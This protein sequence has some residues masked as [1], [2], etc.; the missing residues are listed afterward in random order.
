MDGITL[1][2]DLDGT[3]IDTAPDLIHAANHAMTLAGLPAVSPA[4]VR[5]A[6]SHGARVMITTALA[7]HQAERSEAEVDALFEG[8]LA[9]YA[10]NIAVESRPFPAL[11]DRLTSYAGRGATLAVCTNKREGLSRQLLGALDLDHR[12][13]AIAG[14]DTFAV[15]KPD[16]EHLLGT[17]RLAG[18]TPGRA[19]M[20]GDSNTDIL[21][22]KAAGIPVI[23]VTFGY[24]DVPVTALGCDAVISH[25]DEMDAALARLGFA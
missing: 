14:R 2:F 11:L 4:I 12:F 9:Y 10:D 16:P 21:T 20:V 24:T 18:G 8:F 7:H 3:L 22:A 25:Y 17:I 1:V 15:C 13:A 19:V 23:G 5:P 6:I